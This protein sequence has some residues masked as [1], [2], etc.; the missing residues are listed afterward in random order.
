MNT[1]QTCEERGLDFEEATCP[2]Q[3]GLVLPS[4]FFFPSSL[5][6]NN[7]NLRLRL[8][9]LNPTDTRRYSGSGLVI[10]IAND[11]PLLLAEEVG[12]GW[13]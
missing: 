10:P 5:S 6:E 11:P 1:M 8:S 3:K 7:R 12:A 4:E 2:Y 13:C 9:R